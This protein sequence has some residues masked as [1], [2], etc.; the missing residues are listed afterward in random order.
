VGTVAQNL[1]I[2]PMAETDLAQVLAIQ[3][4][5]YTEVAPESLESIRSKLQASPSTCSVA[6]SSGAVV[7]YLI[8]FPSSFENPPTLNQELCELPRKPDCLYLHDLAIS[9]SAR[10]LGVGAALV[11]KFS[12]QLK[13]FR[14]PRASLIAVQGSAVYWERFGFQGVDVND[15]IREK[16]RSYGERVVYMAREMEK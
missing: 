10:G 13:R 11:A 2:L 9:P 4:V 8:A 15:K 16:L 5:C 14:F 3:S 7:G 6:V 12:E 1:T